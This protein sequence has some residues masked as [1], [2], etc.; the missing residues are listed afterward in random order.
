MEMQSEQVEFYTLKPNT[1]FYLCDP[2]TVEK[3]YW[4]PLIPT[5]CAAHY[6]VSRYTVVWIMF[7]SIA[8]KNLMLKTG[9]A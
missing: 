2:L 5:G 9:A 1:S 8:H 4:P 7:D 3:P 6:G